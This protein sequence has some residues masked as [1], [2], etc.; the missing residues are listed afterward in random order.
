MDRKD[1][2]NLIQE[3]NKNC[4]FFPNYQEIIDYLKQNVQKGDII[5]TIGAGTINQVG[6]QLIQEKKD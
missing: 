5:I 6:Y 2:A 1:L 4:F 3:K